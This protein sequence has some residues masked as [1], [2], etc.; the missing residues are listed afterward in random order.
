[1]T[2]LPPSPRFAK[3][4]DASAAASCT[5]GGR[6]ATTWRASA[7][8]YPQ[9]ALRRWH[10]RAA[11]GGH[12]HPDPYLAPTR[13]LGK[14]ATGDLVWMKWSGTGGQIVAQARVQR[15]LQIEN[16][17]ADQVRQQ[18]FGYRLHDLDDYW[19]SVAAKGHFFALVVYL[20]GERWLDVP[21]TP[22]A[23]SRG[24][25]WIVMST[26]E[27]EAA[28]LG[29]TRFLE[30]HRLLFSHRGASVHLGLSQRV[31][32]SKCSGGTHSPVNT[33]D[34]ERRR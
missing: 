23:R 11:R 3:A 13:A 2:T 34:G 8:S 32:A 5:N 9:R 7:C 1:M 33:A 10:A 17:T 20:E 31:C 25:S 4:P 15:F 19:A 22:Q 18:T 27:L 12:L 14:I 21:I 6:H 30:S 16:C 24:E 29:H 26:P 28:W